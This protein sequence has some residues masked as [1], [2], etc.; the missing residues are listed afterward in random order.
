[1]KRTKRLLTLLMATA[2]VFP[3]VTMVFA[4]TGETVEP[5]GPQY[6][7]RTEYLEP[8]RDVVEGEAGN[9][10][11]E[12]DHFPTGGGFYFS[13]SGG[14]TVTASVHVQ[15]PGWWEWL[16]ASVSLGTN[17][18]SGKFVEVPR[19]DAFYVLYIEK[20]VEFRPYVTYRRPSG[21]GNEDAW[22]VYTTGY[23]TTVV[24]CTQY[25]KFVKWA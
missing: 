13:D 12:G 1:M 20:T 22:E 19:T 15:F 25:A 11:P 24:D 23:T 2:M 4:A 16:S 14:P 18:A 5:M 10:K 8:Y 7:Y 6:I 3:S 17:S 21:A 9:N